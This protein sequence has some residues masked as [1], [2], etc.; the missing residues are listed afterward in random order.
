MG[1]ELRGGFVSVSCPICKGEHIVPCIIGGI[2]GAA[3][4]FVLFDWG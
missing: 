2:I 4:L 1:D 3:L